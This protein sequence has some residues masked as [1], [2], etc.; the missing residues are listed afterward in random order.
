MKLLLRKD[1]GQLGFVG[2]VVEV[3]N[4]YARNHLIPQRFAVLPT[5]AN[6]KAIEVEKQ[7]A[8]E[9][10]AARR[11]DLEKAVQKIN[12]VEVTISAVANPEGKLYG[13][14]G[15]REIAAALRDEGHE[16]E[17]ANIHMTEPLRTLDTT[18]VSVQFAP[19]LSAEVKVW[20]VREEGFEDEAVVGGESAPAT[21]GSDL[22][23]K[24]VGDH[25]DSTGSQTE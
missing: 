12:Q 17:A 22:A 14:V 24:E 9:E 5:K 21:D 6:L 2:D 4:G 13:S 16:I 18:W 8:A 15:P 19:D 10:R 23:D 3:S 25:G 1:V 7:Q 11:A 20:V